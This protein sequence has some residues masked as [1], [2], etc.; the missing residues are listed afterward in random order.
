[1]ATMP[2]P[3]VR[4]SIAVRIENVRSVRRI[5]ARL[6]ARLLP[7]R[8]LDGHKL[9]TWN[10]LLWGIVFVVGAFGLIHLLL[11]PGNGYVGHNTNTP[12]FT[13]IALFL[14]FGVVSV[15]FW[16][17]FRYRKPRPEEAASAEPAAE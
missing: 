10:R 17:Y 16:G 6:A 11:R 1:M 13:V 7:I 12:M 2:L 14:A 4:T 3:T 8:F 9:W 15:A 5:M